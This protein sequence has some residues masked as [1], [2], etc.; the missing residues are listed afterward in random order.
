MKTGT[1]LIEDNFEAWHLGPCI[2]E[3]VKEYSIYA[4]APILQL[5]DLEL[6]LLNSKELEVIKRL[7]INLSHESMVTLRSLATKKDCA[8]DKTYIKGC[9]VVIPKTLIFKDAGYEDLPYLNHA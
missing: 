5:E 3:V 9:K 8:W 4:G 7:A 6:K 1:L 2:P